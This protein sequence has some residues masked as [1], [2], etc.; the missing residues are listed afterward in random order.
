MKMSEGVQSWEDVCCF[1]NIPTPMRQCKNRRNKGRY[2]WGCA[3]FPKRQ[4]KF[5]AWAHSEDAMVS[6]N[7]LDCPEVPVEDDMAVKAKQLKKALK[8]ANRE[9][10]KWKLYSFFLC[11]FCIVLISIIF[12]IFN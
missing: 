7:I 1:C 10:E 12:V 6:R 2:F 3:N 4:C 9:V 11:C 5:F 8:Q